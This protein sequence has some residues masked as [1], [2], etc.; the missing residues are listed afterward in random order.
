M[1]QPLLGRRSLSDSIGELYDLHA[2][3]LFAYCHDQLGDPDAASAAVLSVLSGVPAERRPPRA[4]LYAMARGEIQR[5][6]VVHA[7]PSAGADPVAVFVRRVLLDLRPH[8]REVLYLS[9]VCG[10]DT[11]E[12]SWVLDVAADTADELTVSACRRFAQS[13]A[14]ALPSARPPAHLAGVFA[15][16]GTAQIRDVLARAPWA[17]PPRGLRAAVLAAAP[18]T[19]LGTAPGTAPA[20]RASSLPVRRLW[21]TTPAWPLPLTEPHALTSTRLFLPPDPEAVSAHEAT[22]EPMPRLRG[23]VLTALDTSH[24]TARD[25]APGTTPAPD[26]A[27]APGTSPASD[28]HLASD[29]PLRTPRPRPRRPRPRQATPPLSAPVPGDVLDPPPAADGPAP[30]Q[31][32]FRPLTPEARA[33]LAY[34]DKLVA[35]APLRARPEIPAAA[36]AGTRAPAS[37]G[38]PAGPPDRAGWE[39]PTR[40]LPGWPLPADQLGGLAPPLGTPRTGHGADGDPAGP[41]FAAPARTAPAEPDRPVRPDDRTGPLD[42]PEVREPGRRARSAPAP[43]GSR[44]RR[45]QAGHGERHHDWVWEVVGFIICVAIAMLVFFAVPTIVTP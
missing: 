10:M 31:D 5:R 12:L 42:A 11:A 36:S 26:T 6:D 45:R 32:L 22:T 21:P 30:G 7:P 17:S 25:G 35:S 9:G 43:T 20:A 40:P 16:L 28:P 44:R 8:Q 37:T 38:T 2:S 19:A 14:L 23:S 34:T 13:L 41:V 29:P 1:T 39:E 18:G 33:A 15:L 3:G 27:F 24:E 4:G